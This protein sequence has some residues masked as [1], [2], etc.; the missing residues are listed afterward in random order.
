MCILLETANNFSFSCVPLGFKAD[1][2]LLFCME[3]VILALCCLCIVFKVTVSPVS[4]WDCCSLPH[5]LLTE[6]GASTTTY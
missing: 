6:T 4:L 1:F 3:T 5:C 2:Y